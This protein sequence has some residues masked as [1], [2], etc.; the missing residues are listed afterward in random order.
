MHLH[1]TADQAELLLAELDRIFEND[2][3]PRS[4]RIQAL[5]EIRA[6][7]KPYPPSA[8]RRFRRSRTSKPPSRGRYRKR[9]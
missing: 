7:L 3:Y 9:R 2:R 8:R 1:L 4:P 5:R 6:L